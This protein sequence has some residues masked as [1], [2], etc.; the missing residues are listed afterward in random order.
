MLDLQKAL[1]TVNHDILCKKLKA[2]GIKSVDWFRPYLSHRNQIVHVNDT[3]PDP[4]IETCGVPQGSILGT[5]LYLCYI[6]DME[7]TLALKINCC[8][9][10]MIVPFCTRTR[11]LK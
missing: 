9:M 10:Q 3:E 8:Y 1:D 5:F 6:N 11:T 2:M 7:L 4:S